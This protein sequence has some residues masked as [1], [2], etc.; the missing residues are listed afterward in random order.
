MRN[1]GNIKTHILYSVTL[2]PETRAFYERLW[3]NILESG[4]P[5]IKIWRMHVACWIPKAANTRSEY[6]ILTDFPLQ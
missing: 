3:E 5:Q 2:F 4:M 1:V 6:V